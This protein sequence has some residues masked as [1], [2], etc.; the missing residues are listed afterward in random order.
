MHI[1]GNDV[2]SWRL[3]VA[4]ESVPIKSQ[5]KRIMKTLYYNSFIM[6]HQGT[7]ESVDYSVY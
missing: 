6:T 5:N 2:K 1:Q 4:L 7:F 3:R